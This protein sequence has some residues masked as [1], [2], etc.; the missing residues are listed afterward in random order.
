MGAQV[1]TDQERAFIASLPELRVAVPLPPSRPYEVIDDNGEVSGVHPEILMELA[2]TFGLRLR[3]VVYPDWTSVLQA[4]RKRDVDIV[5]T[6]GVT[7]ERLQYLEFTLGV[8]S[9]PGA[10]FAPVRA[11]QAINGARFVLERDYMTPA[12]V[13][14][15]S[16]RFKNQAELDAYIR[17]L[18]EQMKASA[19]NLDFEKAASLRDDIK[20]LRNPELGLPHPARRA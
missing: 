1:L 8:T 13:R 6:I 10:L 7:T 19:T 5:M 14:D 18:Q 3:P 12:A 17:G 9:L 4:A 15:G 2:Q 16:I 11:T 20:R